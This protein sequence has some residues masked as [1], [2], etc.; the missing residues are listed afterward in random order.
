MIEVVLH[1]AGRMSSA[2]AQA[3]AQDPDVAIIAVVSPQ[4]PGWG[5]GLACHASLDRLQ[6]RPDVLIDFSL[7]DGT[8][9]AASWCA[10]A[11][12]ALLSG[13][14]G[15]P[16]ETHT[17]LENAASRVPVLWSPNLSLGVNL[18]AR[19]CGAAAAALGPETLVRI[20][21]LHHQ[22]KKDAPSGTALML[23]SAVESGFK[24]YAGKIQFSSRREGEAV[25]R[26]E[27]TFSWPGETVTLSHEAHDRDIFARGALQAAHWLAA[28]PSGLYT[29]ADWL[30]NPGPG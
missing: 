15:L 23:G 29:A 17:L 26:H 5:E 28:Q 4:A 22:W 3:A 1:G 19:L 9:A 14:T 2:V 13:V 30:A 27:V 11:G 10:E 7:P 18:L 8:A 24:K 21:D 6:S 12:V 16:A 20:E 25:G